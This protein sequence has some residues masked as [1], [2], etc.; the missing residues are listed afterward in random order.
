MGSLLAPSSPSDQMGTEN[1]SSPA[2]QSFYTQRPLLS[3]GVSNGFV[4]CCA[5][6]WNS[7]GNTTRGIRLRGFNLQKEGRPAAQ[8]PDHPGLPE[9]DLENESA[10]R[11]APAEVAKQNAFGS[12]DHGNYCRPQTALSSDRLG[13]HHGESVREVTVGGYW[14]SVTLLSRD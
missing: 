8:P 5:F 1:Q 12:F 4:R 11:S 13:G 3:N 14:V 10:W 6:S 2:A 7:R 9:R